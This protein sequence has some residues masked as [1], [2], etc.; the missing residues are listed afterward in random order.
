M[1]IKKFFGSLTMFAVMAGGSLTVSSCGG[2][3][4]VLDTVLNII[5]ELLS[6]ND[7]SGTA[8]IA[9]DNSMALEF[10]SNSSGVLYSEDAIGEDGAAIP[11][12]FTYT[13]DANNN[14]LTIRLSSQT[15]QFG[16]KD[17]TPNQSL[18]LT[19]NGYTLYFK[20][21]TGN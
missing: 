20:P 8:W 17:F 21:Y 13:I 6:P 11:Q 16:I 9:S 7:L 18:T 5:E 3:D 1:K 10:S 4:D 12:S 15:L 2:N 14:I 19:Y